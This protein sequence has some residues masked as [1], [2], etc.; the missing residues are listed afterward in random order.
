MSWFWFP[1]AQ[2]GCVPGVIKTR[3]GY[4][5]GS[6]LNPTYHSMGD[7]TETV[8]IDYDPEQT[9]YQKMLKVF[10]KNH[11]PTSKCSRQYMSAIFYHDEEQKKMAEETMALAQKNHSTPIT[12][13][14]M[15]G[16][17]FYVAENY[18]QKYLLQRHSFLMNALDVEPG[19]ELNNC[20]VAARINGYVGGYGST[21]H[22]DKEWEK[23]GINDKM[24]DYIRKQIISS[25]RGSC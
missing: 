2:F 4:A 6:K 12:T 23:W 7:H 3:V 11:D 24:A 19:E 20:H 8:E 10:W 22:F 21:V 1:E 9:D 5:G 14:I 16:V 25:F 18:H 13:K 17:G 15:P